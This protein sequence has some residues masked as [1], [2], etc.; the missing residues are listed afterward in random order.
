[1]RTLQVVHVYKYFEELTVETFHEFTSGDK[2]VF[3]MFYAPDCPHCKAWS[4]TWYELAAKL[5][6]D[7]DVVIA[8]VTCDCNC[9]YCVL[10]CTF[11]YGIALFL[12]VGMC[13][14]G[15]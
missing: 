9:Y 3:I 1:M 7:S 4:S 12:Y 2:A 11:K 6:S 10:L 8:Q 14:V 5:Q 13:R 15:R